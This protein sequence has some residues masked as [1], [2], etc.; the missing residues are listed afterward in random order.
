VSLFE[1][2]TEIIRKGKAGKPTEFGKMVKIQ[3]A[4]EQIV[5]H[6]EVYDQRPSESDLLIPALDVHE[7]QFGHVPR[8][9]TADAG[10]F[11][12]RNE[13]VAHVRGVKRVAIPNLGTKS[14]ERR[15]LQRKRWFRKAAE[16]ANRLRG[17]HQC[18][19]APSRPGAM[20]LQ[21]AF[22][23]QALG[24][25]GRHR[26]QPHQHRQ[27]DG[28]AGIRLTISPLPRDFL[29]HI[30]RCPLVTG[31]GSFVRADPPGDGA[32][33]PIGLERGGVGT[34]SAISFLR[35]KVASG[36]TRC[37]GHRP[38]NRYVEGARMHFEA[39]D[40]VGFGDLR[41]IPR[42]SGTIASANLGH[43]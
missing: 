32:S 34:T 38:W 3:E 22:R 20:S 7:Q 8:L 24:G 21:G 19:E 10:F 33:P 2:H 16:M 26:R 4:E 37:A 6:Y 5:T 42:S 18:P 35:R 9:V 40:V 27:S 23:Y 12:A 1:S 11:S 31:E 14:V 13:A 28:C 41:R 43:P 30:P 36:R 29:P 17:P 39:L 15:A 25:F